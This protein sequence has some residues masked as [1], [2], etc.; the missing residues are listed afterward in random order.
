[1]SQHRLSRVVVARMLMGSLEKAKLREMLRQQ[2]GF[3]DV[4]IIRR[5]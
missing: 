2:A 5:D 3:N 1:M 4:E